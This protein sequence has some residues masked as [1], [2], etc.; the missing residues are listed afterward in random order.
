MPVAADAP[1]AVVV[2]RPVAAV[3]IPEPT[4]TSSFGKLSVKG[5]RANRLCRFCLLPQCALRHWMIALAVRMNL[6]ILAYPFASG[7]QD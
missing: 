1:T 2:I 6:K 5:G 4:N 3:D 7:D